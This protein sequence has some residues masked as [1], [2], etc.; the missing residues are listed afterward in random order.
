[1]TYK[2]IICDNVLLLFFLYYLELVRLEFAFLSL[3]FENAASFENRCFGTFDAR[4]CTN[5]LKKLL[6]ILSK[7]FCKWQA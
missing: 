7:T 3:G 4:S 6:T 2:K 1:M 5:Y